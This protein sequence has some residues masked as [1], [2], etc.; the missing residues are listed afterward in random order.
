MNEFYV[1]TMYRYAERE[2]HS[3][4]LGVFDDERIA[5]LAGNAEYNYRGWKYIPET[6]KFSLNCI[7]EAGEAVRPLQTM[8][9]FRTGK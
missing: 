8:S 7:D 2:G 4:V 9:K 1:V 6:L 5:Y 3:Y